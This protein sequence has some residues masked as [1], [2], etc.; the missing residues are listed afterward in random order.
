[1]SRILFVLKRKENYGVK[2]FGNIGLSTG[3]YNSAS[4]VNGML[5][6]LGIESKMAVVKDNNDIDREVNL[7]KPTHVII[8]ALWVVPQKFSVL[9]KL[10]HSVKWII[11]LHSETPFL[12]NEGI[13]F[14]WI[15]DYVNFH[16]VFIG[17]NS[18]RA[19]KEIET[20]LKYSKNK[21]NEWLNR[22][23]I[24]LPNYYPQIYKQKDFIDTDT[25]KDYLNISCFGAIRPLK[26]HMLQAISALEFCESIGKKLYFHVNSGRIE[27]KGEPV[28]NNL[29]GFF[30]HLYKRGHRLINHEWSPR[31]NFLKLCESMDIGMQV[32]FSET[33]NIV[34]ADH[35]VMGTPV[36]GSSE[37]P[38][39]SF[40]YCANPTDSEN[41][42]L[43]LEKVL[44][45]G[46]SSVI[47]NQA[48]LYS[49]SED[50]K[51][52]WIEYLNK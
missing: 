47:E 13:A 29:K 49:Y 22:K 36:V 14:D 12:A 4:F 39:F 23:L 48:L 44:K 46:R 2:D 25:D 28:V 24:Y 34:G 45:S 50:T 15:G 52:E 5:N 16:N 43:K 21:G 11:R 20:F 41:I 40:E 19:F 6:E 30:S 26:N 3:L 32:S 9:C 18:P 27:M 38:W 31:E 42:V 51:K 37:I 35:I 17:I 7:Y 1:M 8:E 33:F 10:H